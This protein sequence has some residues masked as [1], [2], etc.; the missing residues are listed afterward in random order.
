MSERNRDLYRCTTK[1]CRHR[2]E[3]C[4]RNRTQCDHLVNVDGRTVQ[5]SKPTTRLAD[6]RSRW[7][8]LAYCADHAHLLDEDVPDAD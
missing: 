2:D 4:N 6:L 7:F 5:C 8:P 1:G 3:W